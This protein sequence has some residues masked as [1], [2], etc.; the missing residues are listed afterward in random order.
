MGDG[1]RSVADRVQQA[2]GV[3]V[4]G[5]LPGPV[6]D[7]LRNAAR[8]RRTGR[9]LADL[10]ARGLEVEPTI[11]PAD[12]ML[13]PRD[14]EQYF[15]VGRSGLEGIERALAD[16][17]TSGADVHRILDVPCGHGRVL[18]LLRARWPQ[19][20][21]VAC[22]LNR[23]AVDFCAATFGARGV[24]SANPISGVDAPGDQ[25]LVWVGS[26]LTHLDADRWPELLHWLRDRLRP[27][28]ILV[29]T[30]HGAEGARRM[31]AGDTY[32]LSPEAH[33]A[34][35]ADHAATGF[36]YAA[37]PWDPEYGVSLSSADWV[38]GAVAAVD[39]LEL[40]SLREAA[41]ADHHAVVA[42]RRTGPAR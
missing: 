30:T 11:D 3:Q 15:W 28:G 35:L 38:R 42:L 17:G 10:W 18:R 26:L 41:W 32:G 20:E 34:L 13:V 1:R 40:V 4:L 8:R 9:A 27:G 23:P 33:A 39:G 6:A 37:Y 19:A 7:P 24:Y 29:V 5:R 2:L 14:P 22:D 31:A 21:I 16:S 36:G 25:D 12:E